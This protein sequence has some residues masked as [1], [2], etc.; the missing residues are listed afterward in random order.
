M[1]FAIL[2]LAFERGVVFN[3]RT[4]GFLM[5]LI[6]L[7]MSPT[8]DLS[9]PAL[10]RASTRR[11]AHVTS[12]QRHSCRML[13][14]ESLFGHYST[15][16]FELS[17]LSG[18]NVNQLDQVKGAFHQSSSPAWSSWLISH[19]TSAGSVPAIRHLESLQK[20]LGFLW[21]QKWKETS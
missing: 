13:Q 4:R 7:L 9:C 8:F 20:S 14:V 2:Y 6:Q 21:V 11:A 1:A 10:V 15:K 12:P 18:Q 17:Q 3:R 19:L 5:F 16:H